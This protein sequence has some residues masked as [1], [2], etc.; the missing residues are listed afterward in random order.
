[1][2]PQYFFPPSPI[3]VPF[4]KLIRPDYMRVG[5]LQ[6][7]NKKAAYQVVFSVR[8]EDQ[9]GSLDI[10]DIKFYTSSQSN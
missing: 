9:A 3:V 4:T 5:E 8:G 7:F 1:M 2:A 10:T 6:P